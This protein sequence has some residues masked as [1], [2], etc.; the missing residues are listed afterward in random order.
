M[1]ERGH[2]AFGTLDQRHFV[3][4]LAKGNTIEGALQWAPINSMSVVQKLGAQAGL[5]SEE[6]LEAWLRKAPDWYKPEK[7]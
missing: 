1:V 2:G 5:L 4:A 7:L 3:A 6:E